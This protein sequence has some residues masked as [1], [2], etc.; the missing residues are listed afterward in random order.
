MWCADMRGPP[1]SRVLTSGPKLAAI[2]HV[3]VSLSTG[4]GLV[5]SLCARALWLSHRAHASAAWP[6]RFPSRPPRAHRGVPQRQILKFRPRLTPHATLASLNINTIPWV[7]PRASS[8]EPKPCV[9]KESA[10]EIPSI[11]AA[12]NPSLHRRPVPGIDSWTFAGLLRGRPKHLRAESSGWAT[13]I[14][15][16]RA[17][18]TRHRGRSLLRHHDWLVPLRQIQ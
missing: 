2:H 7:N 11:H 15:R 9:S 1:A 16:R 13:S 8:P 3:L 6:A 4:S 10:A 12:A 18:V 17:R 14:R 5:G